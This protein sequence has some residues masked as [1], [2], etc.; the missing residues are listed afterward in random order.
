MALSPSHLLVEVLATSPT[1][2][3][4]SC[5]D[6]GSPV[7]ARRCGALAGRG[8]GAAAA[9][10]SLRGAAQRGGTSGPRRRDARGQ[11]EPRRCR[12][13]RDWRPPT[14]SST[15]STARSR[16]SSSGCEEIPV[17]RLR[18]R[19][20]RPGE[21]ATTGPGSRDG[22]LDHLPE[23]WR[24]DAPGACALQVP[25]VRLARLLLRRPVLTTPIRPRARAAVASPSSS[26]CKL[27]VEVGATADLVD[28]EQR[29]LERA[30]ASP[31]ERV[32]LTPGSFDAAAHLVHLTDE[33]LPLLRELAEQREDLVGRPLP[34]GSSRPSGG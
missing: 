16:P 1:T 6:R 2:A 14:A 19:Y 12:A 29:L 34:A 21:R 5:G 11:L 4:G 22:P 30:S 26:S 3:R 15:G 23:L 33:L 7:V 18:A 13:R 10:A 8:N 31:D 9:R 24:T 27:R 20:G 25:G 28:L 17:H 32:V